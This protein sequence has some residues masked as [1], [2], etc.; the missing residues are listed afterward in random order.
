ML[1]IP[2]VLISACGIAS[3]AV[4]SPLVMQAA[5]S[6]ASNTTPTQAYTV[7]PGDTL[8]GIAVMF[9]TTVDNVITLNAGMYPRLTDR[10]TLIAGWTI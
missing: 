6:L 7:Q 1:I 10:Q 5:E 9:G 3:E 2:A 8:S 4:I